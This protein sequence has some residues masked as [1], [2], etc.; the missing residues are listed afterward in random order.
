LAARVLLVL[1]VILVLISFI[2]YI[3]PDKKAPLIKTP[4]VD[5]STQIESH[6]QTNFGQPNTT[7]S[8]YKPFLYV[9]ASSQNI[10]A[11]TTLRAGEKGKAIS[12]CNAIKA[13]IVKKKHRYNRLVVLD[14]NDNSMAFASHSVGVCR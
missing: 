4:T 2:S 3:K 14:D 6:L 12:L 1:F 8:W 9:D 11:Y 5:I 7:A 10:S 13:Y